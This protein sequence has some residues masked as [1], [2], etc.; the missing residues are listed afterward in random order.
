M[1]E[2]VFLQPGYAHYRD[3][4]FES[5][6]SVQDVLFL[7]V[8]GSNEY[9]GAIKPGGFRHA[10]MPRRTGN[11]MLDTALCLREMAPRIVI[12][13]VSNSTHSIAAWLYCKL[14]RRKFI[15]W[16]EEWILPAKDASPIKTWAR[17]I[18]RKI[19]NI[20]IRSA[21][22]L[23]ASGSA[24]RRFALSVG[25][26]SERTLLTYQCSNDLG[27]LWGP[28]HGT[29]PAS[30]RNILFL[31]RHI[32]SKGLDFLIRAFAEFERRHPN[33]T[34]EI[35]GDG[36]CREEW[37][38]LARDL[39]VQNIKFIGAVQPESTG[40]VFLSAS[41]FVLPSCIRNNTG[42]P[43]GLV[44]NEAMSMSLPIIVTKVVGSGFDLVEDGKNGFIV[45]E[46]D[47]SA[48]AA[49]MDRLISSD[50]AAFGRASRRIFDEKNDH[51]AMA[52]VFFQAISMTLEEKNR[53]GTFK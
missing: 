14:T 31:S 7:Y 10:F 19:G 26:S 1:T 52:K 29:G 37:E 9:P 18:K 53:V 22:V 44:V 36:P 3:Q 51:H 12:S 11:V 40:E 8:S 23:I 50:L 34:L 30:P 48:L 16:I 20:L 46:E 6:G 42:E 4:L 32:P 24:S 17:V 35:G 33:V 39:R 5:L 38:I 43:W 15:L 28:A 27:S 45:P 2:I 13:S 25:A 47:V 41:I 21:D 49:A